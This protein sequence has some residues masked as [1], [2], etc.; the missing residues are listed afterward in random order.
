MRYVIGEILDKST[1]KRSEKFSYRVGR[2][3]TINEGYLREGSP[4]IVEY[5]ERKAYFM[6]STV[7]EVEETDRGLWV[8]TLNSLY[9]FDNC[10][11]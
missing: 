4:L 6:T 8:T 3:C 11:E 2:K 7:V 10:Y 5:P 1:N 9:R